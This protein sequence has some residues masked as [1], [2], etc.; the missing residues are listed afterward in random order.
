[1]GYDSKKDSKKCNL[2]NLN[3]TALKAKIKDNFYLTKKPVSKESIVNTISHLEREIHYQIL[4]QQGIIF[5]LIVLDWLQE[6]EKYEHCA[7]ILRAINEANFGRKT[8][9]L[10]PT[11][12]E[13]LKE[14]SERAI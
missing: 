1:M 6:Q 14:N 8:D 10:L 7:Q 11:K 5:T 13:K 2:E 4:R 3:V 9:K 12:L